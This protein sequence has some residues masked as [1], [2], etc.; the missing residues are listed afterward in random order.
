MNKTK[1]DHA[2]K[3]LFEKI[4]EYLKN[5]QKINDPRKLLSK[6]Y[7]FTETEFLTSLDGVDAWYKILDEIS[8]YLVKKYSNI[9]M[10][11]ENYK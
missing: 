6:V 4:V 2:W 9:E 11:A 7:V 8:D 1:N 10:I 3:K 5:E